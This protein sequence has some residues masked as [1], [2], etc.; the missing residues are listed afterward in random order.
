MGAPDLPRKDGKRI[1][2]ARSGRPGDEDMVARSH[3][4]ADR[5]EV[6]IADAHEH[7]VAVR[8]HDEQ[9]VDPDVVGQRTDA[10]CD[11]TWRRPPG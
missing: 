1:G 11:A 5:T 2:P 4:Q 9:V 7:D 6:G 8:R 10:G 3:R